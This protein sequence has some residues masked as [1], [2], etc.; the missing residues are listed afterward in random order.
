MIWPFRPLAH[1]LLLAALLTPGAAAQ[2]ALPPDETQTLGRRVAD[3][4]LIDETGGRVAVASLAGKP[5]VVSPIFTKCRHTCPMI[6]ANLKRAVAELGVPGEDFNVL[7]L[8]FD[9]SDT[10]EE[11]RAYRERLRL[12]E[13][14]R[15]VRAESEQLLPFLESLDF[16][17]ISTDDG[18]FVHPNLVVV[19]SPELTV[20]KY[21]YG[22]EYRAG[23]LA[24][25]LEIARGANPLLEALGP[26]I[27]LVGVLG[28]I[29]TAFVILIT[30][31][32]ARRR[33]QSVA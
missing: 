13:A 18:G 30:L 8:T 26:Y 32:R 12:P 22:V 6:T 3:A 29:A 9:V 7:S 2:T 19:L 16:R 28:V 25:A 10:P 14:W 11:L 20:A 17:F 5:L 33:S 31:N 27:F 1:A 21:L 23:D 4:E 15:L 24:A